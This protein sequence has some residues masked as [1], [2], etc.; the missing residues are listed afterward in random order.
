MFCNLIRTDGL[1]LRS[2]AVS[3]NSRGNLT[4]IR[5]NEAIHISKLSPIVQNIRH[6]QTT[7]ITSNVT[8]LEYVY[9][10]EVFIISGIC[11]VGFTPA[12]NEYGVPIDF[13]QDLRDPGK[14]RDSIGLDFDGNL[15]MSGVRLANDGAVDDSSS[16]WTHPFHSGDT[17]GCGVTV[18]GD[19]PKYFFTR[20]GC[21]I[22]SSLDVSCCASSV[23]TPIFPVV[24][25]SSSTKTVIRTNFGLRA[26]TPFLWNG[27]NGVRI[28]SHVTTAPVSAM[29][30]DSWKDEIFAPTSLARG[31]TV[32][33]A[34][35]SSPPGV[36]YTESVITSEP[37]RVQAPPHR[38]TRRHTVNIAAMTQSEFDYLDSLLDLSVSDR[39]RNDKKTQAVLDLDDLKELARELRSLASA[40]DTHSGVLTSLA[41]VCRT[42]FEQLNELIETAMGDESSGS[43]L[44]ELFAVHEVLSD[45]IVAAG[46]TKSEPGFHDSFSTSNSIEKHLILF[47]TSS[48]DTAPVGKAQG[49]NVFSLL[50]H[51]RGHKQKQFD[52]AW[53]LLR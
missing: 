11:S 43:D 2:Q 5:A 36:I 17:V 12:S 51:L 20:N 19:K 44:G 22:H 37:T 30:D 14:L 18:V 31:H 7:N 24:G 41:G 10:F 49:E 35:G 21:L 38:A 9:Y 50:C 52:A 1:T 23:H 29:C 32:S 46:T 3:T 40:S 33:G 4:I 28:I 26:D 42:K 6:E 25:L 34:N 48:Q 8:N 27:G 15:Y 53:A 16:N 13:T 47:A 45:A 39:R